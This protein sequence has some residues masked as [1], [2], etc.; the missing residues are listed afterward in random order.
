MQE[1]NKEIIEV[2][3][4]KGR[5]I[6]GYDPAKFRQDACGAWITRDKYGD[7]TSNF[8][9]VIDHIC[10]RSLLERH[11]VPED[12]VND[13][14]NL[15]PMHWANDMLKGESYPIFLSSRYAVEGDN[16]TLVQSFIIN[17]AVRTAVDKFF[18]PFFQPSSGE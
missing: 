16:I 1:F 6:E 7:K 14:V 10:P 12:A 9:W 17:D 4:E 11:N 15:Q 8:G 18:E 13:V 3:W 5:I 2:V